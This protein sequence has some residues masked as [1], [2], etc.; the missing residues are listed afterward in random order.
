MWRKSLWTALLVVVPALGQAPGSPTDAVGEPLPAHALA[1]FGTSRLRH[2]QTVQSVALSPDG[3]FIASSA[4]DFTVRI[5]ERATGRAVHSL[6]T[7]TNRQSY[8]AP[9]AGTPC[10]RYSP[11]GTHLAAA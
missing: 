11:D 3:R 8:V 4:K 5:W 10:I 9:E 1:R 2:D 6:L 7:T